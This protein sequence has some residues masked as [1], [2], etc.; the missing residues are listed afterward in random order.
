M[1]KVLA[2][3]AKYTVQKFP[4]NSKENLFSLSTPKVQL[5]ASRSITTTRCLNAEKLYTEKHEWIRIDGKIGTVGISNYAQE[6]LGDIVYA[7]LPEIGSMIE[8]E[9]ECG[10]LESVKAASEL[11]SPVSGKVIDKNELVEKTPNLINTSCY[12]KGWLFKVEITN[13]DELKNLMN[14]DAYNQYLKS[15]PV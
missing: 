6:S 14:E 1:A 8:K 13:P 7:Q 10:A 15:D 9:A 4:R 12:E 11:F 3:M 5:H 2:Q